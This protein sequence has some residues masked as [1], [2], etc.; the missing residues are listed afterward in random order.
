LENLL[1]HLGERR[2]VFK[3]NGLKWVDTQYSGYGGAQSQE[4]VEDI[5]K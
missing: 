3:A 4:E 5:N 1:K 2:K